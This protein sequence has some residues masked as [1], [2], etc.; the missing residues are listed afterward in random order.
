MSLRSPLPWQSLQEVRRIALFRPG[1]IGD[2]LLAVPALK[3]LRRAL[4]QAEIT[5]FAQ[6]W[7]A[8]FARRFPDYLDG[9]VTLSEP[10]GSWDTAR[11]WDQLRDLLREARRRRYDLTLQ[12]QAES[13][14]SARFVLEM[15]ARATVGFCEDYEA[16]RQ[17]HLTLPMLPGE[18]E[19][20]RGLRLM[21]AL[22]I[23]PVDVE[24]EFPEL[25]ED[26]GA[27]AGLELGQSPIVALHPGA[28]APARRWPMPRFAELAR[29]LHRELNASLILVGGTEEA[30]LAEHLLLRAG[31][32]AMNMV[33]SLPIGGLGAL[34]RRV[35]LFVGNDSGPAQLAAAV[36]PASVRLFGPAD[37]DRWAPLDRAHHRAVY[38]QVE[39]SPC[40]YWECP[41]DHRC[42]ARVTVD[43]VMAEVSDLL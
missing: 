4:P 16:G 3:A 25:P 35:D 12:L 20:Q 41:I 42:L 8:D 28:R 5:L 40:G 17:F 32:P 38:Q 7:A 39:C 30:A 33:G 19:V 2:L 18:P 23:D 6:P 9:V 10:P 13:P 11:P 27:L 31:V 29:R 36:S 1:Q 15:G 37:R 24:L 21:D 43:Q 34:L 26:L 14:I 22:G